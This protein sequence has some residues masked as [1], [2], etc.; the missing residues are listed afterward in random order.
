MIVYFKYF[1]YLAYHWNIK[2]AAYILYHEIKGEKKLKIHTTGIDKL[3]SLDKKD[4]DISHATIYMPVSY[5]I[6]GGA[7]NYLSSNNKNHF[8]DIGCGKGRAMCMAAHKGFKKITGIDF[9]KEL[10]NKATDNLTITKKIISDINFK[11]FNNDAF[12][13]EIPDDVDCIFLFNP[14]DEIIMSGVVE[15]ILISLEKK[16]RKLF[17]IY[18]NPLHKELFIGAGFKEVYYTIKMKYLEV[19]VLENIIAAY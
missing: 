12:Y 10:C 19:S 13:F 8:L 5:T 11:I 7:L 16:P 18:A 6:I 17:V 3:K 14:F 15:N 1:F 2:I 4:I 9:S